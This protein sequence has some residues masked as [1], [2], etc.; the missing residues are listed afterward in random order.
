MDRREFLK[1]TGAAAAAGA[2]ATASTAA[3]AAQ[4][5][6]AAPH[7]SKGLKELLLAS[8][9]P[10]E[11]TGLADQASRLARRIE[12][13]T[14]RRYR[15]RLMPCRTGGLE[16]VMMADADLYHGTEHHHLGF[17]PAFAFFAGLPFFTGLDAPDLEAWLTVG[18]GQELW[19]ELAGEFNVKPMLAGHTGRWPGLWSRRAID[20]LA[21]LAGAPVCVMGLGRDVMRGIGADPVVVSSADIAPALDSGEI[22]AA[23]WGGA[24]QSLAAGLPQV[25]KHLTGFGI[26]TS[27]TAI[28]FGVRASLWARMDA[29]DRA[30]FEAAAAAEY[31][32]ALAEARAHEFMVRELFVDTFGVSLAP[33]PDDVSGALSRVAD[34]VVAHVAGHDEQA[35]AINA[36]YMAFRRAVSGLEPIRGVPPAA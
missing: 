26:N 34:A 25:A 15:V 23:E 6:L 3:S 35:Q 22:A 24:L 10:G 8:P 32:L 4:P 28:S 17:H 11:T 29:A 33:F 21:D 2:T 9:W 30:I 18:G 27:G 19:D 12:I 14:N 13:A 5:A 1:S 20:S 7:L 16:A 31:R 36:S